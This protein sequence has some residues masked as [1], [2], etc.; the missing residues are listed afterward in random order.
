MT[1]APD[2]V[3]EAI[4]VCRQTTDEV[5]VNVREP[6]AQLA[7]QLDAA[8]GIQVSDITDLK[9]HRVGRQLRWFPVFTSQI[10]SVVDD[11]NPD[12]RFR[13]GTVTHRISSRALIARVPT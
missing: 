4:D 1:E 2:S 10:G 6:L 12:F 7:Y 5:K 8:S 9:P 11:L 3:P 13:C